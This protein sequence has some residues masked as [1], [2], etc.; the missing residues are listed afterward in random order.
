MHGICYQELFA[1]ARLL[2][3]RSKIVQA[4]WY[5]KSTARRMAHTVNTPKARYTLRLLQTWDEFREGTGCRYRYRGNGQRVRT[6]VFTYRPPGLPRHA[7]NTGQIFQ[8]KSK[9]LKQ[10]CSPWLKRTC[11]LCCRTYRQIGATA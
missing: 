5:I 10:Y 3:H 9:N 7:C 6:G 2:K 4:R 8:N 11:T 1:H